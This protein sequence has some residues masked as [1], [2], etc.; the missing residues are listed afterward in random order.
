MEEVRRDRS[1]TCPGSSLQNR[2]ENWPQSEEPVRSSDYGRVRRTQL[3]CQLADEGTLYEDHRCLAI[4][5]EMITFWPKT[6]GVRRPAPKLG[7]DFDGLR[8]L[9]HRVDLNRQLLRMVREGATRRRPPTVQAAHRRLPWGTESGP[10]ARRRNNGARI[11]CGDRST[12]VGGR[13]KRRPQT[14]NC[15]P[16]TR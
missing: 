3:G 4:R 13:R 16:P 8:V 15:E 2:I 14:V 11:G 10:D 6:G 5:E 1:A 12:R 7:G 9:R